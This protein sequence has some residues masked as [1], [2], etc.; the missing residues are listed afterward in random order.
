MLSFRKHI[1]T[2]LA[3]SLAAAL[4][5]FAA[6]VPGET[7]AA[8]YEK[9][10]PDAADG[11]VTINVRQ[12]LDS[13][14]IKKAGLD[15]A[16]AGEEA[17]KAMKTIGLDPLKDIERVVITSDKEKS[18]DPYFIIQGKFDPAKL[19]AAI[20]SHASDKKD[21]LKIHKTEH[22][23]IYEMTKLDE[24][25]KLP[26]QAAGAG[27][28]LKNK[29]VFAVI[30][31]K[32]NVVLVGTK[33]SAETVLAKAAGKKTTKL[34]N[35]ELPGL[36]AKINAKQTLAVALPAPAGEEKVKSITGGITV[37]SD[38]KSDFKVIATDAD[39]AKDLNTKIAE[40][41]KQ[42]GDIAGL[43]ALNQKELAPIVDIIGGVKHEAKDNAITI[44]SEIKG[45]TLE[46]LVKAAAEL[47][48]KQGG[49]GIK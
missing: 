16:L 3:L 13:E 42:A 48:A 36:L 12:L 45:D 33:E 27:V 41:L 30:P 20:E 47:A 2:A 6:P 37:T 24:I 10:L 43:I 7:P 29:S 28:N 18:D 46:K 35:K 4:P 1:L 38:V 11:V 14:L 32:G 9:Y 49:G 8:N 17:Q 44:T 22:G 19:S 23:K 26:P 40:G 31:D 25:V 21:A 39:A 5:A 15:K 34:T